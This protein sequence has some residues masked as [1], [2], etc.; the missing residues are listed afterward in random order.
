MKVALLPPI[1]DAERQ[2][3]EQADAMNALI[4][5]TCRVCGL[6]SKVGIDNPALLCGPCRV[7]IEQTRGHVKGLEETYLARFRAAVEKWEDALERSPDDVRQRWAKVEDARCA[8]VEERVTE[9]TFQATWRRARAAGG[10]F[11]ALLLAWEERE[12]VAGECEEGLERVNAALN[13][14]DAYSDAPR[15]RPKERSDAI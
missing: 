11:A 6:R 4:W 10:A 8:V 3:Q 1:T 5:I 2:A 12:K 15:A 9:A 13:E 14:I 7:D